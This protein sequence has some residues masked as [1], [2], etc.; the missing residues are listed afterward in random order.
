M[1][2][3]CKMKILIIQ[4]AF[5]G[6]VILATP[7][8]EKLHQHYPEATIDFLLQKGNESL[9]TD[10]PIINKVLVF[11]KRNSKY[12]NIF[13]L[14]KEVRSVSYDKVINVHRFLSSGLITAFSKAILK[15]GFNKNPLSLFYSQKIKH[16]IASSDKNAHEIKRNLS[17]IKEM[18]DDELVMP[19]LYPSEKDQINMEQEADYI[20]IAPGSIWYTKQFPAEK[21]IELIDG[22]K[23]KFMVLLLG[24]KDD[25]QL[26]DQIC[27][28]VNTK[29]I[30][31]LAGKLNLLESAALMKKAKMN[32]VNDSAP[33]HLASAVNAPVTAIFCSTI[34]EFGFGPLSDISCTIEVEEKLDCRPCSLHGKTKCPEGHFK[35][36]HIDVTKLLNTIDSRPVSHDS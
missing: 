16:F 36:T 26:C 21:W 13:K 8:I 18:T 5:I 30:E 27:Q 19:K 3:S 9:F 10:H 17:L 31:N 11:D 7:L 15:I 22:L 29:R 34:P 32:Y 6:D 20:C 1:L 35:C 12:R 2:P 33:L 23:D 4:T 25:T 14:I 24:G 28:D